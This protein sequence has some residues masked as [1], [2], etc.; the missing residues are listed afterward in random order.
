MDKVELIRYLSNNKTGSKP[1]PATIASQ[2]NVKTQTIIDLKD[3]VNSDG[4]YAIR[5]GQGGGL[6]IGVG[7]VDESGIYKYIESHAMTWISQSIYGKYGVTNQILEATHKKKLSGKWSTPDFSSI[8]VHKFLHTP[9]QMVEIVTIEAKHASKQF[10]VS[11]VYEAFSHTRMATYSILFFHV[12]P[13]NSIRDQRL[14]GVFEEIKLEC[15]RLGVGL[16]IT[17]YP[18]ELERWNYV[19]PS[20]KHEPDRR[21]V[22]AFIEE[23]FTDAQQ[24]QLKKLL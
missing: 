11:C 5:S 20:R 17:E 1:S 16:V 4:I 15:V 13:A 21:R 6:S 22:D 23:A 24:K 18:L 3:E 9:G 8:I 7:I 2:F 14:D 12:D 10:D 19:I